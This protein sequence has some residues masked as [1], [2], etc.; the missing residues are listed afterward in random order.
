VLIAAAGILFVALVLM[1]T[2]ILKGGI[3]ALTKDEK[4]KL[5]DA[6][7]KTPIYWFLIM[8]AIFGSWVAIVAFRP[9]F[10]VVATCAVLALILALSTMASLVSYRGYQ[11]L[12]LPSQF[13]N[14]FL[15]S[16][17]LRLLGAVAIFV[18]IGNW[19]LHAK[20]AG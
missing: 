6:A 4:V 11:R 17:G 7:T 8:V 16:R 10:T 13:L 3:A 19:L 1:A 12:G 15:L 2:R 9:E 20:T 14:A 5:V 18:A